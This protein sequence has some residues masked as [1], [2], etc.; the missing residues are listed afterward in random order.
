MARFSK[1]FIYGPIF[2]M[3]VCRE[4][5]KLLDTSELDWNRIWVTNYRDGSPT[6][7]TV[8]FVI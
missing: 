5:G 1:V 8:S 6:T 2:K 7:T 3:E 4:P